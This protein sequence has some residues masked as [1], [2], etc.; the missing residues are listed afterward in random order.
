M[1]S[2]R[3]D[4]IVYVVQGH[5][6]VIC[7]GTSFVIR[8]DGTFVV[9]GGLGQGASAIGASLLIDGFMPCREDYIA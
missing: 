4:H 9:R 2:Q 3:H 1:H 8:P 6:R 5:L 7:Q